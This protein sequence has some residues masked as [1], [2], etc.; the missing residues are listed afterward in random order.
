MFSHTQY[1]EKTLQQESHRV[2]N[3]IDY[4]IKPSPFHYGAIMH[5]IRVHDHEMQ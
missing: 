5:P 3:S 2:E 1:T 4:A